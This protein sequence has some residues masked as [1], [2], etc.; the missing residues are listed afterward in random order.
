M[1]SQAL[2]NRVP[3]CAPLCCA[4]VQRWAGQEQAQALSLCEW[5]YHRLASLEA[6][7]PVAPPAEAADVGAAGKW[8]PAVCAVRHISATADSCE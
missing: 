3:R 7:M 6:F 8:L 5:L 1:H 2:L 4:G